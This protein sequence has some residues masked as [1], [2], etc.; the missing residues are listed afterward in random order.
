[1]MR[2]PQSPTELFGGMA[3]F[4]LVGGVA[5]CLMSKS[6]IP[7]LIVVAAVWTLLG[8]TNRVERPLGRR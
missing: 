7:L 5:F 8:F 3:V 6:V 4:F 1:V 2:S